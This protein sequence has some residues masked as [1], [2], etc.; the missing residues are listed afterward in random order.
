MGSIFFLHAHLSNQNSALEIFKENALVCVPGSKFVLKNYIGLLMSFGSVCALVWVPLA[1]SSASSLSLSLRELVLT[2]NMDAGSADGW[3]MPFSRLRSV[4]NSSFPLCMQLHF[5]KK[6]LLF[7]CLVRGSFYISIYYLF[8]P[9]FFFFFRTPV[10]NFVS[11][12]STAQQCCSWSH[13][14]QDCFQAHN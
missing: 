2:G 6:Q 7:E 12:Q 5:I 8:F 9:D 11:L 3:G 1:P 14:T 10:G 13:Q 4:E